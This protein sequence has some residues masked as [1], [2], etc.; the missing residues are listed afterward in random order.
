MNLDH[1]WFYSEGKKLVSSYIMRRLNWKSL[2]LCISI[3]NHGLKKQV[4]LV[5]SFHVHSVGC[6]ILDKH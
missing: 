5:E 2:C 4:N 3:C 1:L 6:R